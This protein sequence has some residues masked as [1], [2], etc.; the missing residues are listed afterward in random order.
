MSQKLEM[1]CKFENT[2]WSQDL[3]LNPF[4]PNNNMHFYPAFRV[5]ST[6]LHTL[7]GASLE[8][9]SPPPLLVD[10]FCLPGFWIQFK[11]GMINLT[12]CEPLFISE[13]RW[14]KGATD[15]RPLHSVPETTP[16]PTTQAQGPFH[17][18]KYWGRRRSIYW[19]LLLSLPPSY[20]FLKKS[21]GSGIRKMS[22]T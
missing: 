8:L 3:K 20:L 11:V 13:L 12:P 6:C 14:P 17:R 22:V 10:I 7:E 16:T 1:C 15:Q 2:H 9:T 5:F 4:L 21:S 19:H 18:E